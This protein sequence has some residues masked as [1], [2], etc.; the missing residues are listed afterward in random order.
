MRKTSSHTSA[1]NATGA[2]VERSCEAD[3]DVWWVADPIFWS[4]L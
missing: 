1:T 4:S 2:R 3:V